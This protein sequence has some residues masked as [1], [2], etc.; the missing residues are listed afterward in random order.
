MEFAVRFASLLIVVAF[1]VYGLKTFSYISRQYPSYW[2]ERRGP[3]LPAI[4]FLFNS[5]LL[6]MLLL[7]RDY[8]SLQYARLDKLADKAWLMLGCLI[9]IAFGS[10][11]Q[12]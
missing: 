1:L 4:D 9:V 12:S 6:L 8:K 5:Y 11:I 3:H 2:Q 7:R 10:L